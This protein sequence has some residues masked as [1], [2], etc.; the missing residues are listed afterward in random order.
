M[1]RTKLGLGLPVLLATATACTADADPTRLASTYSIVARDPG[2]GEL[3]VAVQ[4]HYF[5]VGSDVIWAEPGV[6]AIATQA[7]LEISYGPRGLAL[8]REGKTAPETLPPLLAEDEGRNVR[9]VAVVDANGNV[10]VHTGSACI[11]AA[12]H[13][14]GEGY[15]V[16]GNMMRSDAVW[17]AMPKAYEG[18][19]GDLADRLLSALEAAEREGGDVRGR[20]SAA[21][22]VVSGKKGDRAWEEKRIDLRVDDHPEPLVELRRLL[23]VH[24]AYVLLRRAG[25]LASSGDLDAARDLFAEAQ[26]LH[27]GNPEFSFWAGISLARAERVDEAVE[28]LR[29]AYDADPGWR[30]LVQRLPAAGLLP[31]DPALVDRLVDPA[32]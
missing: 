5:A 24:R 21:L 11:E 29:V 22:L 23:A 15:T 31:A 14:T 20:Q 18:A 2:T 19:D 30:E 13:A 9:Q 17:K 27:P 6:G 10:A 32:R 1:Q 25:A 7:F 26:R 16:Q 28:Q 4:S 3:G 8:L 12:G